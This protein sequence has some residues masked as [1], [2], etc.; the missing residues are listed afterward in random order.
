MLEHQ[1]LS[2]LS[3]VYTQRFPQHV[4]YSLHDRPRRLATSVYPDN[5]PVTGVRTRYKRAGPSPRL[6]PN[7][8]G[9][10][11]RWDF[12]CDASVLVSIEQH[13]YNCYQSV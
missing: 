12:I 1:I 5:T 3:S 2:C 11:C 6:G 8:K 7:Y 13:R 10:A 9:M 4:R